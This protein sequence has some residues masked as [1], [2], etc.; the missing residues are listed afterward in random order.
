MHDDSG[1]P[2][3]QE[4]DAFYRY[5]SSI[6]SAFE[7]VYGLAASQRSGLTVTNTLTHTHTDIR[8]CRD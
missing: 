8:T 2:V 3:R 4:A 7:L 1:R 6:A 5:P